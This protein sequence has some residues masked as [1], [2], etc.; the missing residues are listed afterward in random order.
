MQIILFSH[1]LDV[2][3]SSFCQSVICEWEGGALLARV[4]N[5]LERKNIV[6]IFGGTYMNPGRNHGYLHDPKN[7]WGDQVWGYQHLFPNWGDQNVWGY[8]ASLG[9]PQTPLHTM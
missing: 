5:L 1:T 2:D 7:I 4:S 8:L 6:L 9:G 3:S